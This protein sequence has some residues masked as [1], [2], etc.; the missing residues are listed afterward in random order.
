MRFY[1]FVT[2]FF[3]GLGATDLKLHVEPG[4]F[5]WL[6]WYQECGVP[7]WMSSRDLLAAGFNADESYEPFISMEELR[8]TQAQLQQPESID[9]FYTR[10]FFV[11]RCIL[12]ATEEAGGNLLLVAHA[13]SLD[14]CSRF[15]L[16]IL[17]S[18]KICLK[19]SPCSK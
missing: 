15:V 14:T 3:Q 6:A 17:H 8:D 1:F 9:Q 2:F 19:T 11:T 4:L 10:N 16:H 13:V 5:E 7:D 12:Q 18:Q